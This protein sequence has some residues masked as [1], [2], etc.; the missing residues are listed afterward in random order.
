MNKNNEEPIR[1]L[2]ITGTDTGVGKTMVTAAIAAA[3]RSD[4]CQAGVWKP[5]QSGALLGSGE[6]DAEWLL[7]LTG[8]NERPDTV[9][10]YTFEAPLAPMLAAR[11]AGV[12]LTMQELIDAGKPLMERYDALLVEGAGGVA[13]PLNDDAL[14]VDLI[15]ELQIPALIV[16]RS[17]LGTINHTILTA[18]FLR[19]CKIPIIGV[20]LNDGNDPDIQNDPS[21]VTNAELIEQYS[22]LPVLG[23]FPFLP[24]DEVHTDLLIHTAGKSIQLAPIKKALNIVPNEGLGGKHEQPFNL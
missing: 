12:T 21:I 11:Q 18:A 23:R 15:T 16:A 19:H 14:M 24:A 2:F 22:G 7:Q 17:G 8:I 5:V 3:L 10:P 20:I 9:A 1:G 13:V 6:T 4:G